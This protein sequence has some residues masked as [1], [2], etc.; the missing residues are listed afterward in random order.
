MDTAIEN[1]HERVSVL[2]H[3]LTF[4]QLLLPSS[5]LQLI[6]ENWI[7]HVPGLS[8]LSPDESLLTSWVPI[9]SLFTFQHG[10]PGAPTWPTLEHLMCPVDM[11]SVKQ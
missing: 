2:F 5:S 1:Q 4:L 3:S 10:L 9:G 8:P 7:F 11:V 6:F